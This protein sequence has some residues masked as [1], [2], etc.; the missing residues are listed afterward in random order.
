MTPYDYAAAHF[1]RFCDDLMAL[2]RLP[3]VSTDPERKADVAQTA[4]WLAAHMRHIGLENVE[5]M[6]T[7]GHPVVYGDWHN[8]GES[9]PTLLIYGHYDVQPA[10]VE[11]GWLHDPFAPEIRENR[12]YAR[13]SADDKGQVMVHLK[14][15]ESV[16]ANGGCPVNVKYIIEGEEEIG[17]PN[18]AAFVTAHKDKLKADIC[19]ISDTGIHSLAQPMIYYSLRGLLSF[20]LTVSGPKR[21]LHSGYGG[22]LHNPAQ[23]IAEM[24]A[25]LHHPDGSVAVP[26][27]YDD[28]L[29]LSPEER[30][31]LAKANMPDSEWQKM[32]GDLPEW[33]EPGYLRIEKYGARPTLEINGIYGGYTGEGFKTVIPMQAKAKIS[34]RLVANQEPDK[35]WRHIQQFIQEITPPTV[36]SEVHYL[37]GGKPAFTPID[38]PAVQAAVRAYNSQWENP[39]LFARGG[40]SIPIVADLQSI[41]DVPVVL[42]GFSL[43]D[44]AAH[45]PN[46]SFHLEM[47]RKGINTVIAYLNEVKHAIN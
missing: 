7:A 19:I 42:M 44:S 28:V 9:A 24:V 13:G 32:M 1:Q 3:S 35:I 25:R 36:R 22:M 17:S 34:C 30:A 11:D 39:T 10:V 43:P 31:E 38:H 33:G 23:A 12:L 40:G 20:E 4:D 29:I 2:L 45:G 18:L 41:L 21:D 6:P 37:G 5:I 15:I 14:A 16:L 26:G 8:A 46:E 47:Y 27:F